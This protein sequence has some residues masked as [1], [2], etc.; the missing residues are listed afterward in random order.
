MSTLSSSARRWTVAARGERRRRIDEIAV[1]QWLEGRGCDRLRHR[2]SAGHEEVCD[3]TDGWTARSVGTSASRFSNLFA[4]S[5]Q[6][7]HPLLVQGFHAAAS[8]THG[9]SRGR[10]KQGLRG[11]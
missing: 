2:D 5:M 9:G 3:Q 7:F 1:R 4:S 11:R 6:R 10:S 8:C